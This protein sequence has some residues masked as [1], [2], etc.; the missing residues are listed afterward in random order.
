MSYYI[1]WEAFKG[2]PVVLTP[3]DSMHYIFKVAS[4]VL[5]LNWFCTW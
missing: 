2:H 5:V 1:M 4:T 3:Q